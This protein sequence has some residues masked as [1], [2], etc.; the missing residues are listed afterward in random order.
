MNVT[1]WMAEKI[2]LYCD[3]DRRRMENEEKLRE[4]CPTVGDAMRAVCEA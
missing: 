4:Y 2:E 1:D 3:A